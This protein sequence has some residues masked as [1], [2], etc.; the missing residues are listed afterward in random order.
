MRTVYRLSYRLGRFT[1]KLSIKPIWRVFD[2]F[3]Q[4]RNSGLNKEDVV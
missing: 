3:R 1:N 2:A 4:G